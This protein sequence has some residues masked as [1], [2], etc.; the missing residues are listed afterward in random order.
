MLSVQ[1]LRKRERE[2]ERRGRYAPKRP[3][4]Y[5]FRSAM[6]TPTRH[7]ERQRER[8][9]ERERENCYVCLNLSISLTV[10]F[11]YVMMLG[12]GL[13]GSLGR[14]GVNPRTI[15]PSLLSLVLF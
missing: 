4:R 6:F 11:A 5:L 13:E 3:H 10:A 7:P 14:R 2:R 8:E 9:R 1:F 15:A 12:L